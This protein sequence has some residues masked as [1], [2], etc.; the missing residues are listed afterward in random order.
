MCDRGKMVAPRNRGLGIA[1]QLY[2]HQVSSTSRDLPPN[3]VTALP[4]V[5]HPTPEMRD[6]P[7]SDGH[8]Q[9][10]TAIENPNYDP[11]DD[12]EVAEINGRVN[13]ASRDSH[14]THTRG[15]D[16]EYFEVEAIK[17][18]PLTGKVEGL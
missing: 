4:D 7:I 14:W 6:V 1:P 18:D 13:L 8:I 2:V 9:A 5:N 16:D 12:I 10:G 17:D 11:P 15:G 3:K